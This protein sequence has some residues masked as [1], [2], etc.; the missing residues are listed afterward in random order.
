MRALQRRPPPLQLCGYMSPKGRECLAK[1]QYSPFCP[2]HAEQIL[3]IRRHPSGRGLVAA[4]SFRR[5]DVVAPLTPTGHRERGW[6]NLARHKK[7]GNVRSVCIPNV[8]L[9]GSPHRMTV[10][11]YR[12]PGYLVWSTPPRRLRDPLF[13]VATRS[14]RAGEDIQLS[15]RQS[16][17]AC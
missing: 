4:R 16:D 14:I 1:I 12:I 15:Q 7:E 11:S 8:P 5:N 10:G 13:L 6:G 9:R 2:K 17:T 3:G